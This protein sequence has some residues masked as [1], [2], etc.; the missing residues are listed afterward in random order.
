[1]TAALLELPLFETPPA[2][3]VPTRV[4]T[5]PNV[6]QKCPFCDE[7][8]VYTVGKSGAAY[9]VVAF[10]DGEPRFSHK[11]CLVKETGRPTLSENDTP[12]EMPNCG[13][14]GKPYKH[15][16]MH[17]NAFP[18]ITCNVEGEQSYLPGEPFRSRHWPYATLS[19]EQYSGGMR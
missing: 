3:R 15:G 10:I 12:H 16:H 14:C 11:L 18:F 5:V 4:T 13:R 7:E 2:P 17:S 1:M 6:A 8:L 9:I 19:P